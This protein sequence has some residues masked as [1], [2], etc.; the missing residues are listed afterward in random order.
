MKTKLNLFIVLLLIF[1]VFAAA[2]AEGQIA[3]Q[4]KIGVNRNLETFDLPYVYSVLDIGLAPLIFEGLVK[5]NDDGTA[6]VP[7]LAESWDISEDGLTYTFHLKQGVKFSDGNPVTGEDW[8]WSILRVKDIEAPFKFSVEAIEDVTAPDDNTLVIKLKEPWAPILGDLSMVN[9][10]VQEKAY[11]EK[12]GQEVYS[13]K[14]IGTGPYIV[15][16]W[17]KGEYLLLEKN[18]YYHIEGLPKTEELKF[19]IVLDDNTRVLQLEAGQLDVATYVPFSK[20]KEL[21]DN[22]N[23]VAVAI[24]ITEVDMIVLNNT[25]KPLD[26]PKVRLAL[27]YGTDKQTMLDFVSF[28]Y[29]EVTTNLLTKS[30]LFFLIISI[31]SSPPDALITL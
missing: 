23:L 15:K 14:P 29:G 24:P 9:V 21:G 7:C 20:M 30:G 2:S 4:I 16:E 5:S 13:Q 25:K 31:A 1:S 10:S 27:E 3:K 22:P 6:V 28:G 12:V 17:K 19:V 11:Y 18:P 26:D 8:A